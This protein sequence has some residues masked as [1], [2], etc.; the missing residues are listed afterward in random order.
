MEALAEMNIVVSG[1]G[2]QVGYFLIPALKRYSCALWLLGRSFQLA[3]SDQRW[4]V[5]DLGKKKSRES[6]VGSIVAEAGAYTYVHLAPLWLLP[7]LLVDLKA[8][9][10]LPQRVV[11]LSSTSRLSKIN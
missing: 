7:A 9:G 8:V 4:L 2:S 6:L 10:G 1:A 3:K 11:A 5:V